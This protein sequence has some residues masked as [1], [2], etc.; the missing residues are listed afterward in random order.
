MRAT[1]MSMTPLGPGIIVNYR[2]VGL[3]IMIVVVVVILPK[4]VTAAW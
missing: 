4:E 3:V 1:S 2:D